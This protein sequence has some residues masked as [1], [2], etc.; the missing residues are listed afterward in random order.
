MN[1]EDFE[2]LLYITGHEEECVSDFYFFEKAYK[3]FITGDKK[4]F[5][6]IILSLYMFLQN[7]FILALKSSHSIYIKENKCK[8]KLDNK[9]YKIIVDCNL[10]GNQFKIDGEIIYLKLGFNYGDSF[11]IIFE[12]LKANGI[13]LSQ[14]Q[15]CDIARKC[16]KLKSFDT[17]YKMLKQE[18]YMHQYCHS[19][20]LSNNSNWDNA[21]KKLKNIRNNFIHQTTDSWGI[22]YNIINEIVPECLGIAKFLLEES[23]NIPC[24]D[25]QIEDND[26]KENIIHRIK[27]LSPF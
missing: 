22:D 1:K 2:N 25:N 16:E 12:G 4:V 15:F 14:K 3:K 26:I 23:N 8:I 20:T 19:K 17:L 10:D 11:N 9:E 5:K 21:I 18:K 13:A 6:W 27:N 7:L 24:L